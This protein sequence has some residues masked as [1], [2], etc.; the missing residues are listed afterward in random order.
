MRVVTFEA[1]LT[2]RTG[3]TL[4]DREVLFLMA[5]EADAAASF[6]QHGALVRRVRV[7]AHRA[8]A[9]LDRCVHEL[10]RFDAIL[11]IVVALEARL[12]AFV[13]EQLLRFRGMRLVANDT[14]A[15]LHWRVD[16]FSFHG[17]IVVTL[18]TKVFTGLFRQERIRPAMRQVTFEAAFSLQRRVNYWRQR[19]RVFF[20][21]TRHA[22][23]IARLSQQFLIR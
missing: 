5:F 19:G 14:V 20:F 17:E 10:R 8:V 2:L 18:V 16:E 13:P 15:G 1:R 23:C 22:Q 6:L 21:V 3:V 12:G 4:D 7:M 11:E 9:V